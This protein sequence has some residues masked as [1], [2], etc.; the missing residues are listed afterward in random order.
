MTYQDSN[1][2]FP[3]STKGLNGMDPAA[4]TDPMAQTKEKTEKLK[5]NASGVLDDVRDLASTAAEEGKTY[6]R[7]AASDASG[8]FKDAVESN[9]TAGAQAVADLARSAKNAAD[10]MEGQSPQ[11]AKIV[12]STAEGVERISTDIRDRSVGQL[13][14]SVTDFAKRQPAA[15]F[16]CGILAGVVLSRLMRSSDR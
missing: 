12:R 5:Q 9:K 10:E 4:T 3:A 6:A 7:T 15:F 8:A 1:S 14:D 11:I 2:N 16:G 13:L